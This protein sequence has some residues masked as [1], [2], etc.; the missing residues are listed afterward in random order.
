MPKPK[1]VCWRCKKERVVIV[2][3]RATGRIYGD[4]CRECYWELCRIFEKW[5]K[6]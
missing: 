4:F 2:R 6:R 3:V 5:M 1:T